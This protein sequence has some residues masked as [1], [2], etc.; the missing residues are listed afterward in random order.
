MT[1]LRMTDLDLKDQRLLVREDLN[2]PVHDGQVTSDA[3]IRAA[4]PTIAHAVEAGYPVLP[5][6]LCGSQ[7]DLKRQRVARLLRELEGEIPN[8]RQVMLAAIKNVRPSHLLDAEVAEAWLA[9][10]G[11]YFP[12]G[13]EAGFDAA[14]MPIHP[15]EL[16]L[17]SLINRLHIPLQRI[18]AAIDR[19]LINVL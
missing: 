16:G 5:C 3:R 7:A 4:L 6:N 17:N 9:R 12:S 8:L 18:N 15:I 11:D 10:A 2:V 14:Q 19:M 1:V 13:G